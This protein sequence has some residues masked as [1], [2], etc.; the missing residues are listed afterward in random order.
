MNKKGG[1]VPGGRRK[2]AS[3]PPCAEF[4]YSSVVVEGV[5]VGVYKD[6][7]GNRGIER[8]QGK[9]VSIRDAYVERVQGEVSP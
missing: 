9:H 8:E 6:K 1:I 7:G 5:I 3:G 2:L 4:G